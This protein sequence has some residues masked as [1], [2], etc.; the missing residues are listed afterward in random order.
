MKYVCP[1]C[2]SVWYNTS[3]LAKC[4]AKCD[5]IATKN[6]KEA[7]AETKRKNCEKKLA[8]K[9]KIIDSIYSDLRKRVLEYNEIATELSKCGGKTSTCDISLSYSNKSTKDFA[10]GEPVAFKDYP[11]PDMRNCCCSN[12]DDLNEIIKEIFKF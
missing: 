3:D 12:K 7:E 8:E 4:V 9:K 5:E 10:D 1:I 6:K 2:N 11:W